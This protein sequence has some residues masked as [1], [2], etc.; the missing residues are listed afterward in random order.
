MSQWNSLLSSQRLNNCVTCSRVLVDTPDTQC[1]VCEVLHPSG[2][3]FWCGT[4]EI[5]VGGYPE[6]PHWVRPGG[7]PESFC[8]K[9][10]DAGRPCGG[11]AGTKY[12]EELS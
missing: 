4:P 8:G 12:H 1:Q 5:D 3:C 9:W 6:C 11:I 10:H 2:T 7:T